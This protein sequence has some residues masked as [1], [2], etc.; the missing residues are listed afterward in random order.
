[1]KHANVLMSGRKPGA[2]AVRGASKIS[3]AA[4][5][6]LGGIVEFRSNGVGSNG[7]GSCSRFRGSIWTSPV[8]QLGGP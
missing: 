5:S 6:I 8:Q 2:V 7:H 4:E 3:L 1:V